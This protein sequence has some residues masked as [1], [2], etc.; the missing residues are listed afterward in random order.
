MSNIADIVDRYTAVWNEV[1]ADRRRKAVG[2][3][4]ASDGYYANVT[5]EYR[6]RDQIQQAI[7]QAYKDFVEKGFAFTV[8]DYQV[9]HGSLRMTWHMVPAGGGDVA[10]V[11]TEFIVLGPDGLIQSD[12][13]FVDVHP[14]R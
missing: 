3:L 5:D 7:H 2:E 4:W 8:R 13:Q 9:N 11:G 1:D 6:G 14:T 10:A 12:Y